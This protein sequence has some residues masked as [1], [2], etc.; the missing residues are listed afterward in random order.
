M[1]FAL[2]LTIRPRRTLAVVPGVDEV[3]GGVLGASLSLAAV[4]GV[5]EVSGGLFGASL[6]PWLAMLYFIGH[7]KTQA[8]QGVTFGLAF[9]L[10]FVFG[11]IP[12]ALQA[13]QFGV[14]LAD[15]DWL[16]GSAESLLAI[17]NCVVV[18]GFRAALVDEERNLSWA[19]ACACLSLLTVFLHAGSTV[20]APWL[21][22]ESNW[23]ASE[24]ANALSLAT[25]VIHTSS[26]VE[27][28]VAMGL[29][30]RYADYK[31]VPQY[32]GV[33]WGMLPL[34]SS[35][36]VACA[37]HVFFNAPSLAW[38][39]T[40]QAFLTCVGNT[41]MAFACWRLATAQGWTTK[42]LIKWE[43]ERPSPRTQST[44]QFDERKSLP[45]WE[46]LGDAWNADSDANFVLKL[47]G[48]S[49]ASAVIVKALPGLVP[50]DTLA[51]FLDAPLPLDAAAAAL[52]VVPT[53]L[54]VLKW[55]KR[56][57]TKLVF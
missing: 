18:L 3:S 46:D 44:P 43:D 19:W 33:T 40:L 11:S 4:P 17:T 37:Y 38:L 13:G 25:W 53:T 24:P 34:H 50:P 54:N 5:D 36:I 16:H 22:V 51:S 52:V 1:F 9:L 15:S 35:G 27:W 21:F 28:L 49:L 6:F 8:P 29:C 42:D 48:L 57:A 41:T 32:K 2:P 20:H 26:L 39:V 23:Y 14:S 55:R 30:W 47:V 56:S 31:G 12:A 10:V 45:G 7:P